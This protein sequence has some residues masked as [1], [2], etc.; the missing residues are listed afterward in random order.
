MNLI[1]YLLEYWIGLDKQH[2]NGNAAELSKSLVIVDTK[3]RFQHEGEMWRFC[4]TKGLIS[5]FSVLPHS[6]G[7]LL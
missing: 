2:F 3:L 5:S 6:R 7:V 1:S 4:W